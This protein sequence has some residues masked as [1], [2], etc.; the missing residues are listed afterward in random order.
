MRSWQRWTLVTVL[1]ILGL[2]ACVVGF[3]YLHRP[4]GKLPHALGRI[5]HA[6]YHRTKREL[7]AFVAGALLL[8][9]ALVAAFFGR[10]QGYRE[11][12]PNDGA[13]P[14]STA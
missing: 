3:V 4:A 8:G 12:P 2:A 9:L 1:V 11:V 6:T 14:V 5:P 13:P 7:V 10:G